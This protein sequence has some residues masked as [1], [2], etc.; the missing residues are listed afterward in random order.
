MFYRIS[1][2]KQRGQSLQKLSLT[3]YTFSSFHYYQA[4][5]RRPEVSLGDS[6]LPHIYDVIAE[7]TKCW[8][9]QVNI[10]GLLWYESQ[11]EESLDRE[12]VQSVAR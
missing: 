1:R 2:G 11:R 10:R 12:G 6:R 7:V 8:E 3:F 9:G 5:V 4:E